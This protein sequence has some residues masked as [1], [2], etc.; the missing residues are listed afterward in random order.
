ME[1]TAAQGKGSVHACLAQGWGGWLGRPSIFHPSS[2]CPGEDSSVILAPAPPS[3]QEPSAGQV[4]PL[5]RRGAAG[6]V[7][8]GEL[9]TSMGQGLGHRLWLSDFCPALIR[10]ESFWV[11]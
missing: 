7:A 2:A 9:G 5:A 10:S 3:G 4:G 6:E 8:S 1:I 11:P